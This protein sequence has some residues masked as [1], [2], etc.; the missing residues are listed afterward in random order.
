MIF[1]HDQFYNK[2][3][4]IKPVAYIKTSAFKGIVMQ[5]T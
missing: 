5:I 3:A 2:K 1:G 4:F